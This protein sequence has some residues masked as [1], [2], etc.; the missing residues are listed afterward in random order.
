MGLVITIKNN[1]N[2]YIKIDDKN[3]IKINSYIKDDKL[4]IYIDAPKDYL[5]IRENKKKLM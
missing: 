4:R 1:E 5:V 3:I 2:I